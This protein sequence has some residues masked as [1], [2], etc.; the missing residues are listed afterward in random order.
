MT[1]HQLMKKAHQLAK[2]FTGDY[3]ARLSLALKIIWRR[4][5]SAAQLVYVKSWLATK[6]NMTTGRQSVT[7]NGQ[8]YA[9]ECWKVIRATDKAYRVQAEVGSIA[10]HWVPK[11]QCVAYN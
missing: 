1:K 5:K 10:E 2:R 3:C 4:M 11:S 6:N 8:E 7:I 9:D